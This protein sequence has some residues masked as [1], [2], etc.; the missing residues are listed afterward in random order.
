MAHAGE[1]T[2]RGVGAPGAQLL[3]FFSAGRWWGCV[4]VLRGVGGRA[5]SGILPGLRGG[6]KL[7]G[8]TDRD[9]ESAWEMAAAA[10]ACQLV[11]T[12]L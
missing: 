1:V 3:P 11:V 9:R 7:M 6:G 2:R 10:T 12:R 5:C 8:E 4:R